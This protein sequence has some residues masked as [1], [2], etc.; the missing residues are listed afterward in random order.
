LAALLARLPGIGAEFDADIDFAACIEERS[1]PTP[2]GK[3]AAIS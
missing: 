2:G 3:S 1:H